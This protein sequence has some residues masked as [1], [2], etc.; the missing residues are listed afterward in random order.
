M[1]YLSILL[2]TLFSFSNLS[3][4][5]EI[6]PGIKGGLNFANLTNIN[7]GGL[8]SDGIT[9]FHI[10]GTVSFKFAKF[11]TLQPEILYS[12]QGS[13]LSLNGSNDKVSVEL[14]YLSIPVNNKFYIGNTGL[15]FQIAPVL[16]ILLSSKNVDS[17]EG[18]DIA[19]AGAVGF[20]LKNGVSFS[21][22]Y[23]QGL[24][25]IF[26][27]NVNNNNQTTDVGDLVLN[28]VVQLSAGYQFDL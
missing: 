14:N 19:I 25:D 13:E 5:V 15:N 4:Q 23:K 7:D 22:G 28:K 9:S 2:I 17:P 10:G 11:Y 26:G 18:F 6:K 24:A 3:A 12:Q 1:K 8:S 27:R 16:D 21:I 20:E